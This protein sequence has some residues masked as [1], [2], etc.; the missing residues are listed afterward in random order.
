MENIE[1]VEI[2]SRKDW[3]RFLKFPAWLYKRNAFHSPVRWRKE[4]R[5][6]WWK[7]P[8]YNDFILKA[9]LAV[10]GKKVVGRIAVVINTRDMDKGKE[11]NFTRF[12]FIDAFDVSVAL[13][14]A[15]VTFAKRTGMAAVNGPVGLGEADSKGVLVQGFSCVCC[16]DEVYN[17]AY[18]GEHIEN[19]GFEKKEDIECE[20]SGRTWRIYSKEV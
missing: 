14:G 12:D 3:R 13:M 15:V 17:Y 5:M 2:E 20:K 10:K 1:I 4:R 11:A 7:N 16:K 9:F 18:Y 19:L 8:R 6:F